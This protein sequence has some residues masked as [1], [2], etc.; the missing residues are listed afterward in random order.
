L[1]AISFDGFVKPSIRKRLALFWSQMFFIILGFFAVHLLFALKP[2]KGR[3]DYFLAG[4]KKTGFKTGLSL[5]ATILGASAVMGSAGLGFKFG[6]AGSSWLLAGSVGLMLLYVLI[7]LIPANDSFLTL[8]HLISNHSGNFSRR[9]TALILIPS[10]IAIVAVQL[11]AA[12]I[13]ILP[14]SPMGNLSLLLFLAGIISLYLMRGGQGAVFS[15]DFL[16]LFIMGGGLLVGIV[17][18]SSKG[19]NILSGPPA[20]ISNSMGLSFLFPVMLAYVIGPDI[21]SRLL[22]SKNLKSRRRAILWATM[23]VTIFAFSV[24]YVGWAG[25]SFV[26]NAQGGTIISSLIKKLSFPLAVLVNSALLGALISSVDT[27]LFTTS[28]LFSVDVCGK[29][30]K[31]AKYSIPIFALSAV[32]VAYVGKGIIPLM[33]ISYSMFIGILG[34][35]TVSA[36]FFRVRTAPLFLILSLTVSSTILLLSYLI[37]FNHGGNL[38]F[39]AGMIIMATNYWNEKREKKEK[40]QSGEGNGV[41]PVR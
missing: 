40:Q 33:L 20:S 7:P 18:L 30:V 24:A 11:K 31:T 21:H 36:L 29:G 16:Q 34:A 2:A 28:T 12:S 6:M 32:F 9:L 4:G 8:P 37:P 35:P 10:W 13:I 27:T 41:I 39:L 38:A 17:A 25:R 15:S 3:K 5:A 14:Y 22:S 19:P 26:N 23:I 1:N